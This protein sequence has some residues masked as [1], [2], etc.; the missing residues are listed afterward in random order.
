MYLMEIIRAKK[1]KGDEMKRVLK[2]ILKGY[3][4]IPYKLALKSGKPGDGAF[5]GAM[6]GWHTLQLLILSGLIVGLANL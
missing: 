4:Y 5:E 2:K 1:F 6:V 3:L